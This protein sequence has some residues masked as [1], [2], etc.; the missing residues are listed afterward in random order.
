M[1]INNELYN[2]LGE[3]WYTAHDDPV[4]L[5]RAESRLRNPWVIEKIR[6]HFANSITNPAN[7][8]ILDVGCGAGFLSNALAK[9]KFQVT[10]ADISASSLATAKNHDITK[11]VNYVEADAYTL[12]FIKEKYD[13]VCAM[14]F[15][16]HVEDPGRAIIELSRVLKP[17]G[18]F[19]F[20]TFN[21]NWISKTVAI[22]CVEFFV[23]N[24]PKDMHIHRLFIKPEELTTY[25]AKA[26]LDVKELI[27]V[28]PKLF[29]LK[30]FTALFTG[31]VPEDFAFEFTPSL[32]IGY[33]GFAQKKQ[34]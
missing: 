20:H 4:A 6:A 16:E 27:G 15:L 28:K 19:F 26:D 17:G 8:S 9:E 10:G 14:D 34:K 18:L 5:L 23:K 33:S 11:T 24:T 3:R 29:S 21:R 1:K 22:R 32:K 31:V 13:V 2:D 12:P 30:V 7:L 25:C